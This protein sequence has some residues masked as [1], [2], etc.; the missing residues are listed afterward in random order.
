[1]AADP[2][3]MS[4]QVRRAWNWAMSKTDIVTDLSIVPDTT[5]SSLEQMFTTNGYKLR[6]VLKAIYTSDDFV[7]F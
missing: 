3:V 2:A 4:C 5:I 1:M 6:A 7:M